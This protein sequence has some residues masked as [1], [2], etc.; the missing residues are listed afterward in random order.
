MPA[1]DGS[2]DEWR[3][4]S[5]ANNDAQVKDIPAKTGTT[6]KSEL[7]TKDEAEQKKLAL[8]ESLR[9]A[10][11]TQA[12]LSYEVADRLWEEACRDLGN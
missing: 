2:H 12:C 3:K 8:S 5:D 11:C 9:R 10:L 7:S 6:G 1:H 4:E